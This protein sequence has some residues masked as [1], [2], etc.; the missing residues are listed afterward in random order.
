[1]DMTTEPPV[2][3]LL[4]V[5]VFVAGKG[6]GFVE[7][8]SDLN[9]SVVFQQEVTRATPLSGSTQGR[10]R[11]T[12]EGFSLHRNTLSVTFGTSSGVC[13]IIEQSYTNL[14]CYSPPGV[15]TQEISVTDLTYQSTQTKTGFNFTYDSTPVVESFIG[16]VISIPGR[17]IEFNV[18]N[19]AAGVSAH[20]QV[21]F[22]DYVINGGRYNVTVDQGSATNFIFKSDFPMPA[23][24]YIIRLHIKDQGYA[25]FTDGSNNVKDFITGSIQASFHS[26]RPRNGSIH[27]GTEITID[28]FGFRGQRRVYPNRMPGSKDLTIEQSTVMIDGKVCAVTFA[29]STRVKCITP[30]FT[31]TGKKDVQIDSNNLLEGIFES[32]TERTPV[33]NSVTPTSGI[34]GQTLVIGGSFPLASSSDVT[35]KVG[36]AVCTATAVSSSQISCK[37]GT[38]PAGNASVTIRIDRVGDSNN[39]V[40]FMYELTGTV[41]NAPVSS[42]YGGGVEIHIT[43]TGYNNETTVTVCGQSCPVIVDQRTPTSIKC[44]S[45]LHDT[46]GGSMTQLTECVIKLYSSTHDGL[47]TTLSQKYTYDPSKTSVFTD[48][49]PSRVGTGGGVEITFTGTG[50]QANPTITVDGILCSV[51]ALIVPTSI[52]CRT[53]PT[54]KTSLDAH[55]VMDFAGGNGRAVP[56]AKLQVVDVWSS[57]YSWGNNPPPKKGKIIFDFFQAYFIVRYENLFE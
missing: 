11:V 32:L 20:Y 10:T 7:I 31:S 46:A 50:F 14:T 57:P 51:V 52:T 25:S 3:V 48:I 36:D 23:G 1:M 21:H 13:D 30:A 44:I 53:Q 45:P 24:G 27:G 49:Q 29:N 6:F 2:D 22:K 26:I 9:Y 37:L 17:R 38:H 41:S 43:G 15:N 54:N 35:V 4:P 40:I 16:H 56:Q 33:V 55:V 42:G 39:D 34:E 18:S 19:V 47:E 12:L 8:R 28:G 5:S